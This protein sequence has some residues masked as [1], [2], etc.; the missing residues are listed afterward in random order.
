MVFILFTC[1]F[2][3]ICFGQLVCTKFK[4]G[5]GGQQRGSWFLLVSFFAFAF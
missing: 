5:G 3:L 4:V 1:S 2:I